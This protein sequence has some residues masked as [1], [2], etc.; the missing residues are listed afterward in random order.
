MRAASQ[1]HTAKRVVQTPRAFKNW[2]TLLS[3]MAREAVG[4]GPD[5]LTFTTR[6]GLTISCPNK[7]GARVPIYEVFAEDC[8]HFDWFLGSVAKGPFS[9]LDVGG[10]IG[11]FACRLAQLYP[12]ATIHSYEPSPVTARYLRAN[13]EKNGFGQRITVHEAALAWSV[14]TAQFDDN[15]GGSGTNSLVSSGRGDSL[16]GTAVITVPTTTFDIAV[17]ALDSPPMLVKIDCEGGE[18]DLIRAS[19]PES[20][21]SV[22]RLV[23]EY[24]PVKGESWPALRSWLG[25]VGLTVQH[26]ELPDPNGP[27]VV[28]M[29]RDSLPPLT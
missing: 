16:T 19:S 1:I 13:A 7:P 21:Q 3:A 8:Y 5:E 15:E 20:W 22:Q 9:A 11:A 2:S 23:M 25:D 27:G 6:A 10:Q 4:S 17:G 26:E 29:S 18:Y 28:W 12:Q 14:G 24:H